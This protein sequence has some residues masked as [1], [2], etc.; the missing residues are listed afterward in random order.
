MQKVSW[1]FGIQWSE[2]PLCG[3]NFGKTLHQP[4][5]LLPG[6]QWLRLCFSAEAD[7]P[8]CRHSATSSL[9]AFWNRPCQ[10]LSRLV[11]AIKENL[12]QG[13]NSRAHSLGG[14]REDVQHQQQSQL[15]RDT[16]PRKGQKM[17][18][19]YERVIWAGPYEYVTVVNQGIDVGQIEERIHKLV[20][21]FGNIVCKV[22][23]A[24]WRLI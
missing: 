15:E 2:I 7:S 13:P 3:L 11:D 21:L 5:L 8:S 1:L 12:D 6:I 16:C 9:S 19:W 24:V 18:R 17:L 22:R 20:V 23:R 14:E 10:M 4:G